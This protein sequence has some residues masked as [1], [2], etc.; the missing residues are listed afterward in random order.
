[1]ELSGLVLN[2]LLSS[3]FVLVI[4]LLNVPA[5]VVV[6]D[7]ALAFSVISI[8]SVVPLLSLEIELIMEGDAVDSMKTAVVFL[9]DSKSLVSV[10]GFDVS[11]L[12]VVD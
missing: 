5:R 9:T 4:S 3:I 6:I 7:F 8:I 2:V 12:S 11:E 1:M 10:T